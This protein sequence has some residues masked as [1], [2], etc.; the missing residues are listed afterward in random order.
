MCVCVL[1]LKIWQAAFELIDDER[2]HSGDEFLI[3]AGLSPPRRKH[4]VR[5]SPNVPGEM[6][7]GPAK[8]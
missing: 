4:S 8:T 3:R 6:R 2:K 1:G 5:C 7:V